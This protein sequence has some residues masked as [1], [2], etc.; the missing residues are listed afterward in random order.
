[1]SSAVL[2]SPARVRSFR[3]GEIWPDASGQPINAHGA[4]FLHHDGVMYWYGEHKIAGEAGNAAHVGVH[5]YS[6]TDLLNWH[7]EGIAL[8]VPDEPGHEI[9]AGCILERPKVVFNAATR[10]FVMWFHLE[11]KG[12]GYSGARSGVAV[13]DSP[14]GPFRYLGSLRPNAGVWPENAPAE[15]RRPLSAGEAARVAALELPGGPVPY[16]P[17]DILYRRDFAGGQM[18]RD[19]TLFVDEDG[20][21]YHVYA[22]EDNGTLHISLLTEDYL[23]PAGRYVRIFPGGFNEAPALFKRAGR[24]FLITS[25]CTGWAPN[26]ARVSVA[27]SIWGPWEEL[28][29]PC[30]GDNWQTATTFDAQS[31]FVLPVP[32]RE[33]AFIF[34]ADRWRPFDAIDG[35]YVWLPIRFRHGVP[36]IEWQAEWNLGAFGC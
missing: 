6:S 34:V 9:E 24:Y 19:L 14:A 16:Y 5:A 25:G 2:P 33:D 20:K 31:T 1:M 26:Q 7:D 3:P 29:N 18:A 11:P 4:G 36:V 17:K 23:R 13:A 22:S 32:G 27:D 8:R 12:G 15:A 35:R 21:A 10:R 28:G 30:L